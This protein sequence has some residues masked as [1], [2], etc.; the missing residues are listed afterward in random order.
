MEVHRGSDG[1]PDMELIHAQRRLYPRDGLAAHVV[2]YTGEVSDAELNQLEFVKYRQGD[3]IGKAGIE[4][5]YNSVLMGTDGQ[6]RVVVDSRGRERQII[7]VKEAV[8]GK[9]IRLTIDLDL[10]VVAELAM[11][12]KRGAVVALDPR[13]GEVLALVSR[14][15]FDPNKFAGRIRSKDWNELI[16]NRDNPLLKPLHPGPVGSGLHLQADRRPRRARNRSHR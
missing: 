15:A 2:G 4:R 16:S 9:D 14:P 10:Q 7:G 12:E 8:P 11:E 1:F 3:V 6:R 5:Q 13:N